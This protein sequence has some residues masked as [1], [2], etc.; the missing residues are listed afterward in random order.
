MF[1]RATFP[2]FRLLPNAFSRCSR[3]TFFSSGD[4]CSSERITFSASCS[5]LGLID[6]SDFSHISLSGVSRLVRS[7]VAV[8][9]TVGSSDAAF[10]I[11]NQYTTGITIPPRLIQRLSRLLEL[12]VQ[13]GDQEA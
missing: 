12:F 13:P 3:T 11:R 1:L 8:I 10:L 9:G 2:A 6:Y 4:I 5:V 7:T